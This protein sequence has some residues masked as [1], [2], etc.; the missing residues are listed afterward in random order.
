MIKIAIVDDHD[1]TRGVLEILIN[2]LP[3]VEVKFTENNGRSLIQNPNLKK[4]DLLLLDLTMPFMDGF[5]VL[6]HL[7]SDSSF[8]FLKI[9][10]LTLHESQ[11]LKEKAIKMGANDYLLK[12][13]DF[14]ELKEAIYNIMQ[15]TAE[16]TKR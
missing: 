4:V 5:E 1:T 7:R 14:I 6:E 10:V 11:Q 3:K 2:G 13:C 9:I 8:D 15:T 12:D 16:E